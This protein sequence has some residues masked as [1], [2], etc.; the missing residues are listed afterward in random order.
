MDAAQTRYTNTRG[1]AAHLACSASFLEKCRVTGGG[2]AFVKLGRAVRY[3]LEDLDAFA[4]AR[5][6]GATSEYAS[7]PPPAG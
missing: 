6:H 7:R 1:A 5:I 2:P 4:R 3:R